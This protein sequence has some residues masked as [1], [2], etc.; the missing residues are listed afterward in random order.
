VLASQLESEFGT[1]VEML[2]V[3]QPRG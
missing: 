2:R 1:P 3:D